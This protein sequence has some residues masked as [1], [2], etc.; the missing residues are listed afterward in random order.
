MHAKSCAIL[1]TKRLTLRPWKES[2]FEL[3]AKLNADPRVMEYFPSVLTR[4]ESDDYASRIY[5]KLKEQGWGLWAVS[6]PGAD[7][8]GYIG[9]AE[10]NFSAHFTP[11]IEIGWRLAY[12]YW[13]QGYATEGALTALQYGFGTLRLDEI[14]S[15]TTVT[16]MRSRAVMERL[17]MHRNPADDFDHPKLPEGHKLRPHV[18]YRLS[19]T[20]WKARGKT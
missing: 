12:D 2:D 3:F 4:Q 17:G 6:A 11:A 10:V 15:F 20:Q 5:K 18:L 19:H 1:K 7:F 13:G 8:I 9:L 16:N 14:V